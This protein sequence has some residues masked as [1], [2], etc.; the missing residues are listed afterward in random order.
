MIYLLEQPHL[1]REQFYA[2]G[3]MFRI[4]G[5]PDESGRRSGELVRARRELDVWMPIEEPVVPRPDCYP[6]CPDC[7]GGKIVW[8]EAGRAPGSRDCADCGSAF[9]DSRYACFSEV[10]D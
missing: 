5:L 9:A 8:A 6:D 3:L 10:P 1:R 4:G 2:P 7:G